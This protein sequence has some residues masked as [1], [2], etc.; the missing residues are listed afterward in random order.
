[1]I[2]KGADKEDGGFFSF[3]V[4]DIATNEIIIPYSRVCSSQ[5]SQEAHASLFILTLHQ[6]K[7][8]GR[9]KSKRRICQ[10]ETF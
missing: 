2:T 1:M 9:D 3:T 6:R 10:H 5:T 7:T 4:I 8:K